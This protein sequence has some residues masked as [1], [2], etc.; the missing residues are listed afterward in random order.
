M[1]LFLSALLWFMYGL[2]FLISILI[3]IPAFV[4]TVPFDPY[5][6]IPNYLFMFFGQLMVTQNPGWKRT[7]LGLENYRPGENTVVV[8]NHLSFLDMPL[9]ATLPWKMKW[10]S[11][12]EIFEIP[13]VGW[14]MRMAGHVS[15]DRGSVKAFESLRTSQRYLE[16]GIPV[17]IFPEGTRSRDGSMK[18]FKRGAFVL[19]MEGNHHILPIAIHGTFNLMKPDTWRL[20]LRGNLILSILPPVNSV[21]FEDFQQLKDH[22]HGMIRREVE[23]LQASENAPGV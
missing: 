5:R 2:S 16:K 17:M 15:I 4:L 3:T 12:K 9:M 10:V 14:L 20:N 7:I 1:N 8:A 19:A 13:V 23:K 6:R 18:P 22:V 21:D 11:K